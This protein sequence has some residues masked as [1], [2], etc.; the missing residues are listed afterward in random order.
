M[1]REIVL[2]IEHCLMIKSG[3]RTAGIQVIYSHPQ[4]LAQCSAFLESRFPQAQRMASLSTVAAVAD[5]KDSA[6]PAAAIAPRRAA[7]LLDVEIIDRNIQDAPN[8]LTRFVILAH[9]DHPPTGWDKTSMCLSF[10]QRDAPGLLYSAIGEFATRNINL[11]KVESRPTKQSLGEYIFLID[12]EG[13]R[14]DALIS[15]AI[16]ALSG[17]ACTLKVL[18]SYPRWDSKGAK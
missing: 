12:C 7:E 3:T 13:H 14:Q 11:M 1:Y 9:Q 15:E 4:A 6:V 10:Q 8:N 18:G 5:M 2:P 16:A 17:A